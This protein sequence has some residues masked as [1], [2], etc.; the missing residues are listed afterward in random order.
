MNKEISL[1][2]NLLAYSKKIGIDLIGFADP[3]LFTEYLDDN[4]P[5]FYFKSDSP[6]SVIIIGIYL[7]D[8]I[9]DAWTQ[10]QSTGKSFHYLDSVIENRLHL[11]KDFLSKRSYISKIIPYNPGLFLKDSAALAGIGPIGK[12]NLI[13]SDEFGSQIR[14]RAL[15]TDAPLEFG[16]PIYE[17]KYCEGCSKCVDACPANALTDSKY[18][19]EA[20]LSYNLENL[21]KLSKNT[22]IWCNICIESC[23][24]GKDK[25]ISNLKGFSS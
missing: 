18:N 23:P 12:N 20:C 11:I 24:I 7:Y 5:S 25:K 2:N 6:R 17:S 9:L 8:I 10:E 21:R 1:T 15:V 13:I 19:K 4:N 16:D 3:K 22:V 14:L